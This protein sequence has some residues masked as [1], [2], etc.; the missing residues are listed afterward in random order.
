MATPK[1]PHPSTPGVPADAST[2]SAAQ[3]GAFCPRFHHA[4]EVIGRR[5]T[6]VVL[7]AMLQGATRYSDIRDA[8]PAL[9]DKMLVE[10]LKELEA[11]GILRR[12]VLPTT[13]VRVEY[14]L[15]EKGAAL[16][17]AVIAM[18]AWADK[19]VGDCGKG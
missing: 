2:D 9:S 8:V 11:E 14:H 19:W 12:T 18:A 17:S 13:P 5:W 15:T 4:V 1:S 6:G 7:R 10:R 3:D 16:N